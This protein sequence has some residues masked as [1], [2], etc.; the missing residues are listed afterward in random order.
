MMNVLLAVW[1]VTDKSG[2]EQPAV[3]ETYLLPFAGAA[4]IVYG[5]FG[6]GKFR[7]SPLKFE[8]FGIHLEITVLSLVFLLGSVML[9]SGCVLYLLDMGSKIK[10]IQ[11]ESDDWKQKADR[12][13]R[14]N[15]KLVLLIPPL[16]GDKAR[17]AEQLMPDPARPGEEVKNLMCRYTI[18]TKK[19]WQDV[20]VKLTGQGTLEVD[21]DDLTE[22]DVIDSL[23]I[24]PVKESGNGV[25]FAVHGISP[26]SP[27]YPLQFEKLYRRQ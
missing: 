19:E 22:S 9:S 16:E 23:T 11:Q 25:V 13:Q 12:V 26:L 1:A 21:I 4:L 5:V 18:N 17:E 2:F 7:S 8:G 10:K 3:W 6:S 14:F 20:P 27:R 15:V 24:M